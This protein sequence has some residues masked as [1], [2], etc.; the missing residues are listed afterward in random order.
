MELRIFKAC[1]VEANVK[2]DRDG[3]IRTYYEERGRKYVCVAESLVKK[4]GKKKVQK[5]IDEAFEKAFKE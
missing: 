1:E 3:N 4:I 5:L 2:P